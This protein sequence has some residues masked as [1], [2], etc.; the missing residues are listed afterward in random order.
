MDVQP[1]LDE[2]I[3]LVESARSMPMSASCVVN[4]ADVVARLEELKN[5]LPEEFNHARRVLGDRES[6]IE[7]GRREAERVLATA[8]EERGSL[9]ADTEVAREAYGEAD[10]ILNEARREAQR[11]REEADDY[12]DQKL[13]NFEVV[14]TKTL[15][16]IGRGRDKMRGRRPSDE[17]GEYMQAQELADAQG[18]GRPGSLQAQLDGHEEAFAAQPAQPAQPEYPAPPAQQPV[19]PAQ[20]GPYDQGGY[21]QDAYGQPVYAQQGNGQDVAYQ[22]GY[23]GQ[24]DM[25]HYDQQAQ[26]P[27]APAPGHDPA[28]TG[29]QP[30]YDP[31]AQYAQSL[32]ETSFFDTSL[33]DVRQFQQDGG[34]QQ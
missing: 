34:R 13:A 25:P 11:I 17:L 9:I 8:R 30:A 21:T 28:N 2:L 4:R 22:G 10:R 23:E 18:K 12:V 3:A 15:G 16:A 24:Y 31:Q 14:L 27:Y 6:V 7:E 1:K 29:Q 20:A 32:D 26:Q 19:V 33:I 5:L